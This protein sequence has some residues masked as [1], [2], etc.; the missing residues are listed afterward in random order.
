[1]F[2]N[3]GEQLFNVTFTIYLGNQPIKQ[4]MME[5]PRPFIEMQFIQTVQEIISQTQPMKVVVSREEIIWDQFE[6]KQKVI[7]YTMEFQNYQEE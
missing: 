5:A 2:I 3:V 6:Q 7:P 4:W 1:M